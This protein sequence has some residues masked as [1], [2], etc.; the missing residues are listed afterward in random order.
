MA[1][2]Y[3]FSWLYT[4]YSGYILPLTAIFYFRQVYVTFDG[5]ILFLAAPDCDFVRSQDFLAISRIC[6]L[7]SRLEFIINLL[8]L[9]HF[10]FPVVQWLLL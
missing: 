7:K 2:I 5:Y 4:T 6:G 10:G 3:Y 1:A 9:I 8:A